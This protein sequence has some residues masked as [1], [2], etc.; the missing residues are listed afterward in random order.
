MS[1]GRRPRPG[2]EDGSTA[3]EAGVVISL[4]VLL[5]VG[6]IE[7]GRTLWTYN[8]MLLAAEEAG[9]Y[10]MVH[11]NGPGET[12][13]AQRQAS[14]CPAVS[15]TPLANCSAEWAQRTLS[16]YLS[17]SIGVSVSHDATSSPAKLTICVSHSVDFF[18]PEL[19]PYGAFDLTQKVTV[20][21]I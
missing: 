14:R 15:D 13:S 20:P 21:L 18:L 8:T 5:I 19:L 6:S 17:S 4:L 2:T 9:R 12:C 7:L 3:A 10:A 11:H 1:T 16:A